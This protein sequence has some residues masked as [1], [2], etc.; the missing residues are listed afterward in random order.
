MVHR[1]I[2]PDNL[3]LNRLSEAGQGGEQYVLK[4]SDFGLARLAESG[5]T[6]TGMPMGTLAYMSPE[7]CQSKKLDGRSDLYSL[8][9]VLY[10]VVTGY[11]PFQIND[12]SEALDKHV[13]I[14]PPPP[15]RE[16]PGLPPGLEEIILRCL[17]KKPEER[18]ATGTELVSALQ[19]VMSERRTADNDTTPHVAG[20]VHTDRRHRVTTTGSRWHIS[21]DSIHTGYLHGC[22]ARA[23]ARPGRPDTASGR[24][25]EP[26]S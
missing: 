16:R 19:R 11:Q 14:P 1:D 5:L 13:N 24:G 12:F 23:C 7:Q 26:G 18:Y 2:K 17:A 6:T 22:A 8:G 4:I 10:E 20:T 3:L 15:S 21:T 25:E 9:I